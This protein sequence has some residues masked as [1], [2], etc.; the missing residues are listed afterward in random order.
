MLSTVQPSGV[1]NR[2]QPDRGKLVT[3][4]AG[5]RR[6]LLIGHASV[7]LVYDNST[8]FIARVG[9]SQATIT[10]DKRLAFSRHS[11]IEANY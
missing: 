2:V 1:V 5:N 3:F 10:N 4:I 7:N 8:V 11:T 6:R 9:K